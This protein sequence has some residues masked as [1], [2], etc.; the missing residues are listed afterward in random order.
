MEKICL[1][2]EKDRI[3]GNRLLKSMT[4]RA[5]K[6]FSI[7]LFSDEDEL[8]E[9]TDRNADGRDM[10]LL[11]SETGVN[12]HLMN[13][14]LGVR[15]ILTEE[16]DAKQRIR[17]NYGFD[18]E[19]IYR[20]QSVD[21]VYKELL[22]YSNFTMKMSF[23][24]ADYIGIYTP[25]E[26]TPRPALALNM[27]KV[28]SEQRK[29]LYISLGSFS[30]LDELFPPVQQDEPKTAG[31]GMS[32]ALYAYR[33]SPETA[34]EK[35]KAYV[36]T[37]EGIDYIS[38]ARCGE[39]VVS[40]Q[41]DNLIGFLECLTK[42]KSYEV[43]LLD[44]YPSLLYAKD[45]CAMC[46][47]VYMPVN[48]EYVGKRTVAALESYYQEVGLEDT[49]S[50]IVKIRLPEGEGEVKADYWNRYKNSGMYRY[51]KNLIKVD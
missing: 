46:S 27:A 17:A 42:L 26:R 13:K 37:V 11:V 32:D 51:V 40:L 20:Y 33:Q 49:L 21:A 24:G 30:G 7:M 43:I 2:L 39:D 50:R 23:A 47:K 29:V 35:I 25:V 14:F 31:C 38:P 9:Y 16:R 45:I 28:L 6:S 12:E 4:A 36:G 22:D 3:Y 41:L 10:V 8:L 1:I 15:V 18:V 48:D 5:K 34:A 44:I 19:C